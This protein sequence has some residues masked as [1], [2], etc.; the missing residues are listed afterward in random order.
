MHV[1]N[2][3]SVNKISGTITLKIYKIIYNTVQWTYVALSMD[4]YRHLIILH[5]SMQIIIHTH[6]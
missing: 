3:Q 2:Q 6:I 4:K 5:V 1:C